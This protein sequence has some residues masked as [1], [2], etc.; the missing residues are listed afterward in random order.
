MQLV[1]VKGDKREDLLQALASLGELVDADFS[2]ENGLEYLW[3]KVWAANGFV[4][5]DDYEE[6]CL[7]E[8]DEDE[9]SEEIELKY[10][11]NMAYLLDLLKDK[12][13]DKEVI[14]EFIAG[15][16]GSDSYYK[17]YILDVGYSENGKAE[18][19]ALSWTC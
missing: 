3:D 14:K 10:Q 12:E 18:C 11:S 17:Q 6:Q 4:D 16:V 9:E 1:Q 5:M 19:I 8:A 13:S 15:W 2:G 7:S